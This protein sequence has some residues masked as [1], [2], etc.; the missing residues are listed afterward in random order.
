MH[1][2]NTH[3]IHY[4]VSPTHS[5]IFDLVPLLLDRIDVIEVFTN[6]RHDH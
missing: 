2:F 5:A 6:V 4:C 3:I 1:D